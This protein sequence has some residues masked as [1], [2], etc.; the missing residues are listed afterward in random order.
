MPTFPIDPEIRVRHRR[1]PVLRCIADALEFARGMA[2]EHPDPDWQG[3]LRSLER[4]RTEDDALETAVEIEGLLAREGMLIEYSEA[5]AA[6]VALPRVPARDHQSAG[7]A[8]SMLFATAQA[9]PDR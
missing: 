7:R 2:A 1:Y 8:V 6:A 9:E 5:P 4:V 3:I